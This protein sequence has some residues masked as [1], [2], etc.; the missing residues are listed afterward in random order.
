[1]K[2]ARILTQVIFQ[3]PYLPHWFLL[4]TPTTIKTTW[5]F[6]PLL[7][8]TATL[9]DDSDGVARCL[10]VDECVRP[11]SRTKQIFSSNTDPCLQTPQ[12]IK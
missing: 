9:A 11:L 10:A 5:L 7:S 4:T 3:H 8:Q 1:M 12:G 6:P 2:A